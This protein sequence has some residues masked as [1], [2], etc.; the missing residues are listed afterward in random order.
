MERRSLLKTV[1]GIGVTASAA[2][3]GVLATSGSAAA[4]EIGTFDISDSSITTDDGTI[5]EF[6]VS[7]E[8][9][10][11]YDGID[12]EVHKIIVQFG[13][14]T[15][16][17]APY[18]VN[19]NLFSK[20]YPVSDYE[21]LDS[22]AGTGTWNLGPFNCLPQNN[23][24][25]TTDFDKADGDFDYTWTYYGAD[26]FTDG[27][28]DDTPKVTDVEF[29]IQFGLVPESP[30]DYGQTAITPPGAIEDSGTVSVSVNNE[31]VTTDTGVSGGTSLDGENQENQEN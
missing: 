4:A 21:G 26:R 11:E 13:I 8:V 6:T 19:T 12:T 2:G 16:E 18:N 1:G 17:D 24:Q 22:H 10:L 25:L 31:P 3:A 7:P 15:P 30:R 5:T 28:Q 29:Y 23:E 9:S 27:T 14:V 20:R